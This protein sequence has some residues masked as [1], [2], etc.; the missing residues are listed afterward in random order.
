MNYSIGYRHVSHGA[1]SRALIS[2]SLATTALV[3]A[4]PL[5]AQMATAATPP[6]ADGIQDIVVTARK[7]AES[8]QDIPV[9]VTALS[10]QQIQRYDLTTLEKVAAVSPQ[11]VVAR[12]NSGSG[13]Q[14][15]L[16]GIG[17]NFTSIGIEQSVAVVV[18]GV[19]YGQGRV[20]NEGFFDLS[21]IEVLK[22][23]QALFFGK[24]S[25]AGVISITTAGPTDKFQAM[26]RTSYEFNAREIAAEGFVSGP[27]TD[28]LGVR[29]AVKGTKMFG[30][31][32]RNT[33]AASAYPTFD[34]ATGITTTHIAPAP[35]ERA[36]PGER[37]LIG[38]LTI[39]WKP[40]SDLSIGLKAIGS[41]YRTSSP[42][43]TSKLFACPT[44]SSALD[45]TDKCDRTF[46]YRQN[47]LPV[48][49]AT[50]NPLGNRHGGRLYVDYDSYGITNSIDY[51]LS[52]VSLNLVTN[53][54]HFVN[55]FLGDFDYTANPTANSDWAAEQSRY[56]A[57]STEGRALTGFDG[58]LNFL[59]GIYYQKTKLNFFQDVLF[60]GLENSAAVPANARY[61]TF[62]KD[63]RTNGETIAGYGQATLRLSPTIEASGGVRY[64]RETKDSSFFHP[65]VNPLLGGLYVSNTPI[66][67]DQT[68]KNWAPEATLTWKPDRSITAYL[69][70]KQ[71]YKSG[72]FSN[73]AIQSVFST[74]SDFAFQPEKAK[75]FE[76]GIKTSLF[77]RALRLNL[78]VYHYTFSNLQVDFFNSP[79][80]ALVTT[81]AGS[82]KTDGVELDAEWHPRSLTGFS[83]RGSLNY[84]D[85][86]YANYIGPC[87]SGQTIAQG[88]NRFG[89][90]PG[91][92]PYQDLSG[93]PTAAA[94]RWTATLGT[95]Y[96]H[97]VGGNWV[98][99]VSMDARF[100]DHYLASSF[101]AP[102][103]RQ[104]AYV[105]LDGAIRLRT[106][107]D[108]FQI[109]LIGKNLTNR[110]VV[111]GA[112]DATFTGSGTGT[113][114]GIPADQ[115]GLIAAPRTVQLQATVRY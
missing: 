92:A 19:Y 115:A 70:Y 10:A 53:Y 18:D 26:A 4:A 46:K 97:S 21:Q 44:G 83:L 45:P 20:I 35:A 24:N 114:A 28:T 23:P 109:A 37:N 8:V 7:R 42:S 105:N 47:D 74:V 13:A 86:R 111:T 103:S 82:A 56:H 73:S 80:F 88:C 91:L 78:G 65:Y 11:L 2:M 5:F 96:E 12:G 33:A 29:L 101:A 93:K 31:Y 17:S 102:L 38:R 49:I 89:P 43:W 1:F 14:L 50:T 104:P 72:G 6:V 39:N 90:A 52:K 98:F 67:A 68:F 32:F 36:P 48:D 61:V 25:T 99:G 71:G 85:A 112:L 57:F 76:G 62:R 95:D 94:P 87:Y 51:N 75:G 15:S 3:T 58:P 113:T 110:F 41:R 106:E 107:D 63:S 55:R 66:L 54:Q 30:G 16:R 59:V 77:D 22:G 27:V 64:T 60:S 84:N 108:R 69:A 81:N 40:T 9:S 100:S 79:T 34:T